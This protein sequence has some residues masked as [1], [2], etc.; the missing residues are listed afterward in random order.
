MAPGEFGAVANAAAFAGVE[1]M[2]QIDCSFFDFFASVKAVSLFGA[3][4]RGGS[5][6]DS[7]ST[8]TTS[9]GEVSAILKLWTSEEPCA[10][11]YSVTGRIP[12][13]AVIQDVLPAYESNKVRVTSK[14]VYVM[15]T[16]E[17]GHTVNR[18]GSR[19]RVIVNDRNRG[20]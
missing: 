11:F 5:G 7:G 13:R 1:I 16:D 17:E 10:H 14:K 9:I 3:G 20:R 12:L 8:S 18:V 4:R 6:A 19:S 15:L 2:F